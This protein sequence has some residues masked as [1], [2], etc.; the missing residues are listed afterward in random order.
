[1]ENK[2]DEN[3]G[4][5]YKNVI[6][7]QKNETKNEITENEIQEYIKRFRKKR[8]I[9]KTTENKR[10]ENIDQYCQKIK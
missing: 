1:M 8:G 3:I 10:D 2:R 7:K 9:K 5:H 4:H 6:G